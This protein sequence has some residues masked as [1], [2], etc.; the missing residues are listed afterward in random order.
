MMWDSEIPLIPKQNFLPLA[1]FGYI[2]DPVCVE[3]G[4]NSER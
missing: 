4:Q 1:I 3:L 2:A